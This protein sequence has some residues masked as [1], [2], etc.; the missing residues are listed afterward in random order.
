MTRDLSIAHSISVA[1]FEYEHR[2]ALGQRVVWENTVW[3][4]VG[5]LM[6]RTGVLYYTLERTLGTGSAMRVR[7]Y[8]D[9]IMDP[10]P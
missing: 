3:R 4:V 8:E 9:A 2:Y 10:N 5:V 7:V 1:S 6:A